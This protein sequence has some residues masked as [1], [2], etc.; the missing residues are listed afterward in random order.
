MGSADVKKLLEQEPFLEDE[1]QWCRMHRKE[2]ERDE[3]GKWCCDECIAGESGERRS[4]AL[5]QS[6][7][8]AERFPFGDVSR[9]RAREILTEKHYYRPGKDGKVHLMSV[10][11]RQRFWLEQRANGLF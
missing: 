11:N 8:Q 7:K 2:K 9:A 3:N 5:L 10:S 4:R 6:P 1:S